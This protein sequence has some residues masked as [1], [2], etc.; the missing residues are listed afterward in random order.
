MCVQSR[1]VFRS[2]WQRVAG[3]GCV[4]AVRCLSTAA[5]LKIHPSHTCSSE[6]LPSVQW[7]AA[8]VMAPHWPYVGTRE[9]FLSVSASA[10]PLHANSSTQSLEHTLGALLQFTPS[11]FPDGNSTTQMLFIYSFVTLKGTQYQEKN[12]VRHVCSPLKEK[13]GDFDVR[14][15]CTCVL[16][17]KKV[18]TNCCSS[19]KRTFPILFL[20]EGFCQWEAGL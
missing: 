16:E 19:L 2:H 5:L 4:P 1:A 15:S 17:V 18:V 11:T 7:G 10:V 6:G 12:R 3:R 20:R 8:W 14:V 13:E 9:P